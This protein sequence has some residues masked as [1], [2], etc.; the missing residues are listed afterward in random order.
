MN[1]I[2]DV[3]DNHFGYVGFRDTSGK[4]R[5]NGAMDVVVENWNNTKTG[6]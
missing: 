5:D 6:Q 3:G 2:Q 4:L 1:T